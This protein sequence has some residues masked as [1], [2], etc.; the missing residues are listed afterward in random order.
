MRG[1]LEG[2]IVAFYR[3]WK[4]GGKACEIP[5][6]GEFSGRLGLSARAGCSKRRSNSLRKG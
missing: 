4:K 5:K 3:G 1:A 6:L 2:R